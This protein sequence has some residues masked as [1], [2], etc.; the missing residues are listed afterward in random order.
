MSE[1]PSIVE[2]A[3]VPCVS[4]RATVTMQTIGTIAHRITEVFGWLAAHG[5][6]PAG[7]PFVRY[8]VIDMATNLDIEVGVPTQGPV[9][10]DGEFVSGEL[11]AGR[12]VWATHHGAPAGLIA[13]VG[14]VFGWANAR[15]LEFD[16]EQTERGEH[17]GCRVE[18]Y[19]TDP[20]AE[21]NPDNWETDLA[22]RLA[23][24]AVG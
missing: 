8:N 22:F 9:D 16:R 11:P 6:A 17:W 4:L 20:T 13:A 14:S 3:A 15:G 2:R 10:V 23:D 24:Q 18:F 1:E 12:Y 19:N 5:H 7:P 21:P